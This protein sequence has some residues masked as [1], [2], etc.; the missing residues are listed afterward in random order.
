MAPNTNRA[1]VLLWCPCNRLKNSLTCWCQTVHN[2][3]NAFI[4]IVLLE[5]GF[6]VLL[7]ETISAFLCL[8]SDS[9][10]QTRERG[11]F[12][13]SAVRSRSLLFYSSYIPKK[14]VSERGW[15]PWCRPCI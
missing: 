1:N 9:L 3:L 8:L 6:F 7:I 5:P 11:S 12:Q 2:G 10:R 13:I 15:K 4:E 14:C